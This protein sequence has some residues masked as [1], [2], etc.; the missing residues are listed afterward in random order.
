MRGPECW[1][2]SAGGVAAAVAA[3]GV[4]AGVA[5]GVGSG[6]AGDRGGWNQDSGQGVKARGLLQIR[7]G[8][9][10]GRYIKPFTSWSFRPVS[11]RYQVLSSG[12]FRDTRRKN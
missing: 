8:W 7:F 10:A 2:E 9:E 1:L 5:A 4:G 6:A 12:V 3:G 11:L